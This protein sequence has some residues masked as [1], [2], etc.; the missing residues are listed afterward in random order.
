MKISV[1]MGTHNGAATVE[2]AITSLQQQTEPSWELIVC[3]DR[4]TDATWE[5]L[6]RLARTDPRIKPIHNTVAGGLAVALNRCLSVSQAP[7][8]ARMDDDDYSAP[9]RFARQLRA[10]EKAPQMALVGSA[11][12]LFSQPG[13]YYATRA[14]PRYP[15]TNQIFRGQNFVHPTVM[16]RRAALLKVGGYTVMAQTLR[17][18]DFDLW[19]KL[20]AQ[21]YRGMNLT[22]PLLDYR[23]SPAT[24]RRRDAQQLHNV[25]AVMN[26]HRQHLSLTPFQQLYRFTPLLKSWMPQMVRNLRY[27]QVK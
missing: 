19:C 5:I 18:E 22:E 9:E 21:G 2:A 11:V 12:R 14:C 4:S 1:L 8:I 17:C 15:T 24:I 10:L 7:F 23:E 27:R 13:Q 20:Y 16:I 6:Q 3:D 25:Y 26:R